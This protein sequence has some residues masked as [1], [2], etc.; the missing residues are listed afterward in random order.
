MCYKYQIDDDDD[1]DDGGGGNSG[2]IS[3]SVPY[4]FAH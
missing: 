1:D 2:T 3:N 4:L